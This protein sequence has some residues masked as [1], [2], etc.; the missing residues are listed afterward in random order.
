M[1]QRRNWDS[2]ARQRA[3]STH[4]MVTHARRQA[5]EAVAQHASTFHAGRAARRRVALLFARLL[6]FDA[7]SAAA[8]ARQ[9]T[10][11]RAVRRGEQDPRASGAGVLW[12]FR[13][14]ASLWARCAAL[15][16]RTLVAAAGWRW[17][18][19][20]GRGRAP[21]RATARARGALQSAAATLALGAHRWPQRRG[22]GAA[23]R[24]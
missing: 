7:G 5:R 22:A 23:R 6:R 2:R 18:N 14:G 20:A 13:G 10:A 4:R 19:A 16:E 11:G 1:A 3:G 8:R 12:R 24:G 21:R 15:V 9:R 17:R